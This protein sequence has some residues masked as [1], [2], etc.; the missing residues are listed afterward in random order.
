VDKNVEGWQISEHPFNGFSLVMN[1]YYGAA[2]TRIGDVR[3]EVDG[4]SG[5]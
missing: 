4:Y 5:H 3:I 2:D 1:G